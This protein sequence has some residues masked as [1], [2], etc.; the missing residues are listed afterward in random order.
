LQANSANEM[1]WA[2]LVVDSIEHPVWWPRARRENCSCCDDGDVPNY[3]Q[4]IIGSGETDIGIHIDNAPKP[5]CGSGPQRDFDMVD[6]DDPQYNGCLSAVCV[7]VAV[8]V[9]DLFAMAVCQRCVWLWLWLC[10]S[11]SVCL[12][13]FL[14]PLCC[15]V[16]L[17]VGRVA[18]CSRF[19]CLRVSACV[20]VTLCVSLGARV[21]VRTCCCACACACAVRI[22]VR[23]PVHI[24]GLSVSLPV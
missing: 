5:S 17:C 10:P 7:A 2:A 22:R 16:D 11:V 21:C 19:L 14:V 6:I 12:S 3:H 9:T 8:A 23:V 13:L 18:I 20:Y 24:S 15:H 4:V 1:F